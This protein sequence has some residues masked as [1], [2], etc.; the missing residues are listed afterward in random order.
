[1]SVRLGRFMERSGVLPTT[2]FA[3]RNNLGTCD[4]LL[5]LFHTLRS[6]ME[7][8]QESRIVHIDFSAT[9]DKVNQQSM[10]YKHCS[11]GIGGS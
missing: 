1:M 3:Y 4:V 2:Q 11:E 9:L 7:S 10:L 6:A 5:C 8:G